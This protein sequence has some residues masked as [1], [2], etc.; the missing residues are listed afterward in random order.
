[1]DQW[2]VGPTDGPTNGMTDGH[3]LLQRC[4]TNIRRMKKGKKEGQMGEK[5]NNNKYTKATKRCKGN[6]N[7]ERQKEGEKERKKD[8]K[9]ERQK[10]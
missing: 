9:K 10:E 4:E 1:M 2:T 8:R 5:A 7:S 6:P 3:R